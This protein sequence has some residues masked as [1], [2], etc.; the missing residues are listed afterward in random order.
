MMANNLWSWVE[1]VFGWVM[2]LRQRIWRRIK[3]RET[4]TETE[5]WKCIIH[6][7][8]VVM[9][10]STKR[11]PIDAAVKMCFCFDVMPTIVVIVKINFHINVKSGTEWE[12]R[13]GE[14]ER[15]S[16]WCIRSCDVC[17]RIVWWEQHK[18]W[19]PVTSKRV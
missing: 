19:L 13:E 7:T 9:V 10:Y 12:L 8:F 3:A 11:N 4:E 6:R 1:I 16:G 2:R 5:N 17:A 14:R 18:R 15:E